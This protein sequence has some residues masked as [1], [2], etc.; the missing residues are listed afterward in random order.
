MTD[1]TDLA[2]WLKSEADRHDA[3]IAR[4]DSNV[5]NHV[6]T[7]RRWAQAAE[8]AGRRTTPDREA[9]IEECAKVCDDI[10]ENMEKEP[11]AQ[12]GADLCA[13]RIRELKTA[14]NGEKGDS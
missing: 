2:K 5:V 1:L 9:V 14:T 12:Y 8:Q 11:A 3:S 4:D 13:E 7:L 10:A 6:F